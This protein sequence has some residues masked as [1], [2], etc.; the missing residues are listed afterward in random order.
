MAKLST[1]NSQLS[2]KFRTFANEL[3][4]ITERENKGCYC[5]P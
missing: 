1:L 5:C 4:H 2:T 3:K